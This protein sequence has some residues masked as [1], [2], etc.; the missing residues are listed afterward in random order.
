MNSDHNIMANYFI[1]DCSE[2]SEATLKEPTN[3]PLLP[4]TKITS[5][6]LGQHESE[7]DQ[8]R[9]RKEAYKCY[10]HHAKPTKEIM[11][12]IVDSTNDSDISRQD[13]DLLPWN[14][15]ETEVNKEVMKSL[16]K[17][18]KMDKKE[19]K[20]KKAT[21][22][23]GRQD[24]VFEGDIAAKLNDYSA[25]PTLEMGDRLTS[26]EISQ[27]CSSL[28]IVDSSDSWGRY[29]GDNGEWSSTRFYERIAA[30]EELARKKEERRRKREEAK[31]KIKSEL[32]AQE[33]STTADTRS[34]IKEARRDDRLERAF[35]WYTR[36]A[37]P[38][39][40]EFKRKIATQ[41]VDITSEDV[42]LLTWNKTGTRVAN[43]AAMNALIRTK[44]L[45]QS[46]TKVR[47]PPKRRQLVPGLR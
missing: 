8:Y 15:E 39:R 32:D 10:K 30:E 26:L 35:L 46:A 5:T 1:T 18:D 27:N 28:S 16:K 21:G 4:P 17:T 14:L 47:V 33:T 36:M 12:R 25:C 40:E 19:E 44:L 37:M 11:C 20:D 41:K 6:P 34:N 22:R 2:S 23:S 42:D 43:L 31:K 13:V 9:R 3:K 38:N 45:N 7:K 24:S 29:N